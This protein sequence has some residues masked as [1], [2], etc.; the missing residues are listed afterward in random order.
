[1]YTFVVVRKRVRGVPDPTTQELLM[2]APESPASARR[3]Q[4]AARL[5][6]YLENEKL[7]MD[8]LLS[9]RL[10]IHTCTCII[11]VL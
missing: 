3:R 11:I 5:E 6:A 8:R 7:Q 10:I 1:V 2:M 4:R 9:T